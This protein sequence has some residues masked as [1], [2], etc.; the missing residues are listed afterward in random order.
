[1]TTRKLKGHPVL[2]IGAGRGGT[3][4]FEMFME[5][6]LFEV[7]AIADIN[8]EAPGLSLAKQQ[9]VPAYTDIAKALR[10]CM[11][12]PDCIIYNLTHDPAIDETVAKVFGAHNVSSGPEVELFWQ[13]ITNL[14]RTKGDLEKSQS[15]LQ[16][17][18]RNVMDG[19]IT[20]NESGQILGFNPA[21]EKIFGHLQQDILGQNV[22]LLMPE[23]MGSE[24]DAYLSRYVRTG[25]SAILG[26]P[27]REVMAVRKGG[28]EFPL[29]LSVSEMMLAGQ[30]YFIGIARD[31]TERRIAEEKI[32]HL[33]HHDYLT[34]LPNRALFLDR[35]ERAITLAQRNQQRV[36]ILFLDLDGFKKVNDTLGHSAGDLLLQGVALRLRGTVR[37]S[38]TVARVGGDEFTLVMNNIGTH[39]NVSLMANKIV[40]ALSAP[41][42]LTGQSAPCHIGCSVGIS[43][44]PEDSENSET[45]L[46]QADE[47]MYAAKQSRNN[48]YRF[49]RKYPA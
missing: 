35:L 18:I 22:K 43:L 30:R 41:F 44:F 46:K 34:D 45:L 25:H 47:A 14:K 4:L 31:I 8:P 2:I 12:C 6:D 17:V 29:E 33:A 10:A 1:M 9:G 32:A 19:I 27:V 48:T 36:A 3:A 23:S 40:V 11:D 26:V 13:M 38:D 16:A 49:Y 20:I 42:E 28:E 5:E 24:H 7:V 15:Q 37:T 21:A 39:E